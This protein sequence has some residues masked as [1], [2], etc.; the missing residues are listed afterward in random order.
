MSLSR[1]DP[2]NVLSSLR[3]E[4]AFT[5]QR[6]IGPVKCKVPFISALPDLQ[7]NSEIRSEIRDR[8]NSG[9]ASTV[10]GLQ[11]FAANDMPERDPMTVTLE[12]SND[13]QASTEGFKD[14]SLIYEGTSG[15][16]SDPDRGNEGEQII[17]SNTTAYKTYR[18]LITKTRAPTDATQYGEVI[19]FGKPAH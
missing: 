11:F 13:P 5:D 19:L 10:T 16:D 12:G 15:L 4:C 18:L 3:R 17:F 1:C 14:F 9:Q 2:L 6:P 7:N 8:R